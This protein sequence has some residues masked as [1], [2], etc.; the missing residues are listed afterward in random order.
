MNFSERMGL[1]PVKTALQIDDMDDA[2][3]NSLWNA[4][5][6]ATHLNG[7]QLLSIWKDFYKER[8]DLLNMGRPAE[9]VMEFLT[10]WFF[11]AKWHEVY[12]LIEF[13]VELYL[14][15]EDVGVVH[16]I[17]SCN[18]VLERERSGYRIINMQVCP[19]S[20]K[21]EVDEIEEAL[22]RS[23]KAGLS[24][25]RA[26]LDTALAA[27]SDRKRP[28]YRNSVKESVS[29]VEALCRLIAEDQSATLGTA[30]KTIGK[31]QKMG[32]HKAL[33]DGFIKIYGYTSDADGIRHAMSEEANIASEDARYML[34]ACSAFINYLIVKADKA[35]IRL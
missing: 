33:E 35:G 22:E 21:T 26:H 1:R 32:L 29:A 8:F 5:G 34:V 2:L 4:M 31:E 24:G 13:L 3:R 6:G 20:D 23:A 25:V 12:D 7:S 27:L 11:Q 15:S 14:R 9:T 16:F 19:I 10:E 18:Q 17:D 28:D 30:L